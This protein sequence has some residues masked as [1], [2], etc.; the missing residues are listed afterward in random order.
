MNGDDG[1]V[2]GV[3]V[4]GV[5]GEKVMLKLEGHDAGC[6]VRCLWA[7]RIA[8]DGEARGEEVLISGGFDKKLLVWGCDDGG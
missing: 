4:G 6:K 5:D 2:R 1:V 7:G 8:G 3:D